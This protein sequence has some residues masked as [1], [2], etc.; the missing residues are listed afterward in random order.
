GAVD[1]ASGRAAGLLGAGALERQ[2][3]RAG[4]EVLDTVGFSLPGTG[5]A[6][7]S[8]E[9]RKVVSRMRQ[10]GATSV[11]YV[12]DGLFPVFMT[13]EATRQGYGPEWVLLGPAADGSGSGS[14]A[15]V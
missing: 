5:A 15:G 3:H 2:L 7:G 14:G 10:A 12:G 13:Q 9:A 11:L 8:D 4:V 1:E 6:A